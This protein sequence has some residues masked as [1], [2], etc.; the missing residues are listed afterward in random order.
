MRSQRRAGGPANQTAVADGAQ[1]PTAEHVEED[2]TIG[3][4]HLNIDVVVR[5]CLPANEEV[6]GVATCYPPWDRHRRESV[7]NLVDRQ[8]VPHGVHSAIV[9]RWQTYH[10]AMDSSMWDQRYEGTDLV[11]SETPNLFLPPLVEG[12]TPGSA[13]D[14]ACGEGRNAIW[15]ARRGWDV[16]AVDFSAVGI[17]KARQR[18]GDTNVEWVVADV[19]TFEPTKRFDLVVVF[20]LHLPMAE[21]AEAFARGTVALAPGGTIFGVGHALSN[22]EHGVGG[23]PYPDILWTQDRIAALVEGLD[24]IEL[25]ERERFVESEDATAIDVIVWATKPG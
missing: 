8:W 5:P 14:V 25:E 16:T 15:L 6:D 21:T 9:P 3:P 2:L 12:V 22:L 20:Y 7:S 13:L 18:A 23:P 19:T 10:A 24:V 1:V 17:D 11:W 4:E